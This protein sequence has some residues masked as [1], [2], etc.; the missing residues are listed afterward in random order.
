MASLNSI[1]P[2]WTGLPS[3]S[4]IVNLAANGA[5]IFDLLL[6]EMVGTMLLVS[7]MSRY[8]GLTDSFIPS[9]DTVGTMSMTTFFSSRISPVEASAMESSTA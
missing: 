2:L 6:K 3:V 7:L 5:S 4:F 9:I 1:M 8:W